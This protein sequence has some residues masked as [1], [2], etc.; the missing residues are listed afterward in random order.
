MRITLSLL[1]F[2]VISISTFA[3]ELAQVKASLAKLTWVTE[4]YPPYNYIDANGQLTGIFTDSLVLIY[5]TMGIDIDVKDIAVI[6][7]ARLYNQLTYEHGVAAFSMTTTVERS[8]R[9][10]TL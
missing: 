5:Q 6:P 2:I 8:K 9:V 4:D 7:W 10:D 1:F 3:C